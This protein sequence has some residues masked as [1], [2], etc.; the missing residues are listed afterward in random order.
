MTSSASIES[1][2]LEFWKT[3]NF[4]EPRKNQTRK[5]NFY[6]G[7]PFATGKPHYGHVLAGTIKDIVARYYSMKGFQVDR[8]FGWDMH[9]LPVEHEIDKTHDTK[10]MSIYDYNN[11]CRRLVFQE[12]DTWEHVLGKAGHW[13][14]FKN[15]YKTVDTNYM[16]SVWWV[17]ASMFKKN[18]IFQGLKVMPYSTACKTPLS[19][20]EAGENYQECKDVGAII[21]FPLCHETATILIYTTTVWT[22]PSNM[23]I[24]VNPDIDYVLLSSNYIVAKSRVSSIFRD[25]PMIIRTFKGSELV[26]KKYKPPFETTHSVGPDIYTIQADNFVKDT[27]GTGAVHLAPVFGEDD[28]RVCSKYDLGEFLCCCDDEGKFNQDFPPHIGRTVKTTDKEICKLLGDSVFSWS[29]ITHSYPFC[30]RSNTPL[31][32][33]AVNSWFVDV[34]KLRARLLENN[35]CTHWVPK[36]IGEHR[37]H[38]WLENAQIWSISRSRNWGTP[39]PVWQSEDGEETVVIGSIQELS[40][41]SGNFNIT[42][43]HREYIDDITFVSKLSGKLMKRITPVFDC[44]FESGS[45]P[46]AHLHYP[47]E[48]QE[49]FNASFPADFIAEG[50]DQTRGWFYTLLVISTALFDRPAYYNVIVNGLVLSEDGEK[51]SKSKKNYESPETVMDLHGADALRLYLMNSPASHAD[52]LKFKVEGIKEMVKD[53]IIVI[54]NMYNLAIYNG[55]DIEGV[56]GSA[57]ELHEE[58]LDA[59]FDETI[60]FINEEMQ[61]YR[62]YNIVPKIIALLDKMSRWYINQNKESIK[63]NPKY[64]REKI[65]LLCRV[66][67]PFA[68]FITEYI[69]RKLTGSDS[70]IHFLDYPEAETSEH[71]RTL[72]QSME[73]IQ[74]AIET[75]RQIRNESGIRSNRF[76]AKELR[77]YT[78]KDFALISKMQEFIRIQCNVEVIKVFPYFTE[79][80]KCIAIPLQAEFGKRAKQYRREIIDYVENMNEE[81][82]G[83]EHEI[84]LR[85]STRFL[86]KTTDYSISHKLADDSTFTKRKFCGFLVEMDTDVSDASYEIGIVREFISI[87]QQKKRELGIKPGDTCENRFFTDSPVLKNLIDKYFRQIYDKLGNL[88]L[89]ETLSES[90]Q[91]RIKL[92]PYNET[93]ETVSFQLSLSLT[94]TR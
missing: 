11:L 37:F 17:F 59:L 19:N 60:E 21:K 84:V 49:Q 35:K 62:I 25:N 3:Q 92:S 87:F 33:K 53:V 67:S 34:P 24:A 38:N 71:K 40:E 31:I 76:Q 63:A 26:G 39:I 50:L 2:V 27:E 44:W 88:T 54:Q 90:F 81:L 20:F 4:L 93:C 77:I 66:M 7:P 80:V 15:S 79:N 65:I 16:E 57:C 70:S 56:E 61:V 23:M 58:Y 75:A 29:W 14:D 83:I 42:D 12:N 91:G 45:M 52:P 69:Y 85:D 86:L 8:R 36:S 9:G 78:E 74:T 51:M 30:W 28:F 55:E 48:N 43:L 13:M 10:N 94:E 6:C 32:Y 47:F 89:S 18:L 68:P 64:L 82:I 72:I 1:Q 22:L 46:Y 73:I 41:L 5:F